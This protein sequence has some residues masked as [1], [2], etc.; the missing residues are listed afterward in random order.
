MLAVVLYSIQY[1]SYF[2]FPENKST[3]MFVHLHGKSRGLNWL[4]GVDHPDGLNNISSPQ[5][6]VF[7][8]APSVRMVGEMCISKT[9]ERVWSL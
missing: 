7:E 9:G 3:S 2:H 4:H 5:G 6:S 1:S 8:I